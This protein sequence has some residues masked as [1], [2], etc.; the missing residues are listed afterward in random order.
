MIGRAASSLPTSK[1]AG[2]QAV[3]GGGATHAGCAIYLPGAGWVEY[4]PPRELL[5]GDKLIRVGIAPV[6]SQAQPAAGGYVCNFA[7]A[8]R[9]SVDVTV[10]V[11]QDPAA[12]QAA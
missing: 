7:G 2:A 4:D 6:P 8:K 9:V 3:R 11:T 5:A 12:L 1:Y 10:Q